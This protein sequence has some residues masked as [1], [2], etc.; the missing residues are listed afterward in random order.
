MFQP[1]SPMM[2]YAN[3]QRP[4]YQAQANNQMRPMVQNPMQA[5][6]QGDQNPM[7]A[8][9]AAR[10]AQQMGERQ[11][12][13]AKNDAAAQA[14]GA[15]PMNM[16]QRLG[17]TFGLN[18]YGRAGGAADLIRSQQGMPSEI[19]GPPMPMDMF[20]GAGNMP[21]EAVAGAA[22]GFF[23]SWLTSMFM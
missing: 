19:Q 22:G 15:N 7:M 12:Q 9:M 21:P 18:D 17:A 13:M 1:P 6:Q 5:P 2:T 20:K 3:M 10:G 23:P 4:Q 16:G 8:M 14:A 11:D